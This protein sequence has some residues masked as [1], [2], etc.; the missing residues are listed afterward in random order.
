M[1]VILQMMLSAVC[2]LAMSSCA[3]VVEK[4]DGKSTVGETSREGRERKSARIEVADVLNRLKSSGDL[5]A[6][7]SLLFSEGREVLVYYRENRSF[8]GT[9]ESFTAFD[10]VFTAKGHKI[11]REAGSYKEAA[12]WA[13]QRKA[14]VGII[15]VVKASGFYG[16]G[17]IRNSYHLT[18]DRLIAVPSAAGV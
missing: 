4:E 6:E 18:K 7:G 1:R 3:P 2:L 5:P 17:I 11:I 15:S 10:V 14:S 12:S 8:S 9:D 13:K 16:I